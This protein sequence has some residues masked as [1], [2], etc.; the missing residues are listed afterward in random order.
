MNVY[1]TVQTR[2]NESQE[3]H[4][5]YSLIQTFVRTIV[6]VNGRLDVNLKASVRKYDHQTMGD[7]REVAFFAYIMGSYQFKVN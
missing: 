3:M 4:E 6:R 5:F 1:N 2:L 7:N